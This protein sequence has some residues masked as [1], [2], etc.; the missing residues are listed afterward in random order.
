MLV[1]SPLS[2]DLDPLPAVHGLQGLLEGSFGSSDAIVYT[3]V[4]CDTAHAGGPGGRIG[5]KAGLFNI[6]AQGQ[7]LLGRARR[8]RLGGV[9]VAGARPGSRSR[10]RSGAGVARRRGLGLHP[11]RAEGVTGAHEV[12]TTIMLNFVADPP[13]SL[14]ISGPLEAPGVSFARTGTVG[15]AELPTIFG[16]QRPLGVFIAFA[17]CRWSGG[18]CTAA[19]SASRSGPSAPTR[20][21]A[22]RGHATGARS[23]PDDVDLRPAGRPGRRRRDPGRQPLHDR[24]VRDNSG[25]TPSRWPCSGG[26]NP[27]GIML[28]RA[29]VRRDAGRRRAHADPGRHSRRDRRRPPGGDPLLPRG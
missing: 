16:T 2:A 25:S 29:P 3:L 10:S 24:L 6:G 19:P 13:S 1:S 26:R 4:E 15:N 12:V 9:A 23:R 21:R 20:R 5:F 8:P 17:P 27:V 11:G 14:L 7:F 18:C 28:R 22:L